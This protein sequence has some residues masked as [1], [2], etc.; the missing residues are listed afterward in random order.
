MTV[1][2]FLHFLCTLVLFISQTH[3]Q[4]C[5]G[6]GAPSIVT[7]PLAGKASVDE[8]DD[9]NN[10]RGTLTVGFPGE[11]VAVQ[12]T[13]VSF[14]TVGL[15]YCEEAV[16]EIADVRNSTSNYVDIYPSADA[17][18]SPC[19]D[20]PF[21]DYFDLVDLGFQFPT[22]G[23]SIY[24]E[25]WETFD[26]NINLTDANY[27]AG[28]V[29]IY[30][31][32]TGQQL[33]LDLKSFTGT[34]ERSYN[35]L[36]WTTVSE[37]HVHSHAVERSP[38]GT[39]AWQEIG[40]LPSKGQGQAECQYQLRDQAPL[41]DAYYRLRTVE[42]DGRERYSG[43]VHLERKQEG[44]GINA[45]F[46]APFT[47]PVTL[48]WNAV[49]EQSVAIRVLDPAG[50]IVMRRQAEGVR[51]LNHTALDFSGL[52]AGI[53][54]IEIDNGAQHTAPVRVTKL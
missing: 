31:C 18:T 27:T 29:T 3:A 15:S 50:H 37:Q 19:S 32:P 52:P 35:T 39:T 7:L 44:F 49:T 5:S 40:S 23:T 16:I 33:P 38:D 8:F 42:Q 14:N 2:R 4:T 34:T 45:I 17:N 22:N 11:V 24:W 28:T 43:M 54:F 1:S 47:G 46:P 30:V 25:L 51:G 6:G 26:D 20:L 21:T 53:Y 9:N 10:N 36:A 12:V 41:P 13:G 48:Q